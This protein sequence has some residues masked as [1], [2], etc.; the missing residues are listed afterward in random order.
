MGS[1]DDATPV[2]VPISLVIWVPENKADM[3][4]KRLSLGEEQIE[5]AIHKPLQKIILKLIPEI[6]SFYTHI[7]E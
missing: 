5:A 7:P 4:R 2:E 1:K 6:E 3:V